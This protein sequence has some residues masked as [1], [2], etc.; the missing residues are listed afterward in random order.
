MIAPHSVMRAA[1]SRGAGTRCP[2]SHGR[3]RARAPPLRC[4]G[5]PLIRTQRTL[6]RVV[7][8]DEADAMMGRCAATGPDDGQPMLLGGLHRCEMLRRR[9]CD[10]HPGEKRLFIADGKGGHQRIVPVS[11]LLHRFGDYLELSGRTPHR[12]IACSWC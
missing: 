7:D 3:P 8:P 5:V 9:L 11:P 6:P 10:E 12:P 2:A 4:V 1:G